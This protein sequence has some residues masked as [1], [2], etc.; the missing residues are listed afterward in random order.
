[1]ASAPQE[2]TEKKFANEFAMANSKRNLS[3]IVSQASDLIVPKK[4]ILKKSTY[5]MESLGSIESQIE[6][7]YLIV[8]KDVEDRIV[9]LKVKATR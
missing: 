9:E 2:T 4:S 5:S 3:P 1:M 8:F 7:E 6:T